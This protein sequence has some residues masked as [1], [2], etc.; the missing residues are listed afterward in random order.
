MGDYLNMKSTETQSAIHQ[1]EKTIE[2]LQQRLVK[3]KETSR[4]RREH[5]ERLQKRNEILFQEKQAQL[6]AK[7]L[8][9]RELNLLNNGNEKINRVQIEVDKAVIEI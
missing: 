2:D 3:T 7:K 8:L 9:T 4:Y 1:Q 6:D 5:Y